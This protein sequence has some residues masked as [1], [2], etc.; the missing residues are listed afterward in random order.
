MEIKSL[1]R[2]PDESTNR[3]FCR[4][5]RARKRAFLP[6]SQLSALDTSLRVL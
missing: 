5:T 3:E 2:K 1:A 4:E 6:S